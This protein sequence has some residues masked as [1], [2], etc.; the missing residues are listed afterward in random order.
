MSQHDD[1]GTLERR[2]DSWAVVFTRRF[3]H[4]VERVWRAIT[5]PEHLASWFPG[6]M[7]GELRPGAPLKFVVETGDSFE[8]EVRA[9]DPPRLMEIQWGPDV[10]RMELRADGG[11]SVLTFIDALTELG[12]AARDAA[13]WHE[14]LA[15]MAAALDGAPPPEGHSIWK[16]V[17]DVYR[18]RFGPDASTIGPPEGHPVND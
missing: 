1:L 10:L 5:E 15:R 18:D 13:G 2:G 12:K 9:F 7:E 14:C 11:G 8:G 6:R 4:P 3:D 16:A 17:I